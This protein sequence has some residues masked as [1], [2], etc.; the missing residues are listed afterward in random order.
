MASLNV[1]F[2]ALLSIAVMAAPITDA[3][4]SCS[5]ITRGL[6]P[7]LSYLKGSGVLTAN[8]CGGVKA[9]VAAARTTQDKQAA[10]NCLKST[11]AKL[12]K[13]NEPNAASLPAKCGVNI[14]YKISTSIN[15][16]TIK[17]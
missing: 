14:P 13:L 4:I 6:A 9:L 8:C 17:F 2:V 15:C 3:A 10:C 16:A 1:A 11:A 12:G 5:T 7:C